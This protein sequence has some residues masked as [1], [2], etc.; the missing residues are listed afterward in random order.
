MVRRLSYRKSYYLWLLNSRLFFC[1][2]TVILYILIE[3]EV[4]Q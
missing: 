3:T 4:H 2:L 1:V